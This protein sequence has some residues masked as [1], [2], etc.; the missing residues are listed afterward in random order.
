MMAACTGTP[1]SWL[2]LER[3]ALAR[4]AE[5][6][7]HLASCAACRECLDEIERDVVA[8]P[9]LAVPERRRRLR[10]WLLAVPALAAAALAIVVLRPRPRPEVTS[11]KGVGDVVVDVVRERAGTI[12][13]HARRFAPADRWKVVVTCPPAAHATFLV[14]VRDGKT[15]DHPLPAAELACGND[16]LVP[17]AFV[18]TGDRAN[19]VCVRVTGPAGDSGVACVTISPD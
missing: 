8:L 1:I 6:A 14:E 12:A 5:V 2:R 19:E 15:V 13:M 17:G 18:L 4:D 3:H 16:I 7:A 9:P 11:I 10:W